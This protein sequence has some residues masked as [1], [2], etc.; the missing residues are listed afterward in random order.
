MDELINENLAEPTA[1]SKP[2]RD[3]LEQAAAAIAQV[4]ERAVRPAPEGYYLKSRVYGQKVYV[5]LMNGPNLVSSGFAHIRD[6]EP[7]TDHSMAQAF[8]YAA[9]MAFKHCQWKEEFQQPRAD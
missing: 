1:I 2:D 7:T 5:Y 3:K 9:H 8:S 4:L 6:G